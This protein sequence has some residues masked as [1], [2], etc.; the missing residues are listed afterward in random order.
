MFLINSTDNY[1]YEFCFFLQPTFVSFKCFIHSYS[2]SACY[3]YRH[4]ITLMEKHAINV[5]VKNVVTL[6]CCS[7]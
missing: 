2:L 1:A 3:I 6:I 4:L 7:N 5:C